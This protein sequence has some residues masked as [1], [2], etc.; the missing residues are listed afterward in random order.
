MDCIIHF[1]IKNMSFY[2]LAYHASVVKIS[3]VDTLVLWRRLL[4]RV[5][6]CMFS[7]VST[8]SPMHMQCVD[9]CFCMWSVCVDTC[10]TWTFFKTSFK[11]HSLTSFMFNE[12]TPDIL[13]LIRLKNHFSLNFQTFLALTSIATPPS[14]H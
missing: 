4:V 8:H 1:L 11:L 14:H 6:T 2:I 3:S 12:S 7:Y 10:F 9:T 5:D 13:S